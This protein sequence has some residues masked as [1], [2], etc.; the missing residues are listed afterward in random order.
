MESVS[1][2]LHV[3][4]IA[5]KTPYMANTFSRTV[6]AVIASYDNVKLNRAYYTSKYTHTQTVQVHFEEREYTFPESSQVCV[7]VRLVG[8][9]AAVPFSISYT[10][11]NFTPTQSC[12][13]DS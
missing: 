4:C 12:Y 6:I 5:I 10:F 7:I 8:G 11:G 13:N 1:Q 2:Y 9:P 3:V